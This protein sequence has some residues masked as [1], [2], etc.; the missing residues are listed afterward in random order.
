MKDIPKKKTSVLVTETSQQQVPNT[1][2]DIPINRME[3]F[4]KPL[5]FSLL[6][7]AFL[8]CMYLI[9]APSSN[10][11][12]KIEDIGLNEDVPQASDKDL[13]SDKQKA[14]ED[15]ILKEKQQKTHEALESLS[16]YWNSEDNNPKPSDTLVA[17]LCARFG[18]RL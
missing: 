13:Q 1:S 10:D 12:S 18:C 16:D 4:K 7:I 2:S 3:R 9:F 17:D 6:G 8:G 15:E 14:Y 11:K 5:V